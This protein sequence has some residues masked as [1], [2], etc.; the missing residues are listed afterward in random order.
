MTFSNINIGAVPNDGKGSA[1]RDAMIIV[2]EN[3][4]MVNSFVGVTTEQLDE[5]LTDYVTLLEYDSQIASLTASQLSLSTSLNNKAALVHTHSISQIDGLQSQLDSK[6][7]T[8][9]FNNTISNINESISLLNL[10]EDRIGTV[11]PVSATASG[12]AG[13]IRVTPTYIYTC[14]AT[15]TWV[16]A[17]VATWT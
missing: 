1:L 12:T 10:E 13:D 14:V 5:A 2:N 6:V 16:R 11:A 9:V 8:N 7:G 17:V 4:D 3:F 15:N